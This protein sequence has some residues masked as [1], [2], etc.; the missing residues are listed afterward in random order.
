MGN[1]RNVLRWWEW[2]NDDAQYFVAENNWER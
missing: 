2:Q 1:A